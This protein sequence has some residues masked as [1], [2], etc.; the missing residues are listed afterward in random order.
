MRSR[1]QSVRVPRPPGRRGSG[2][3]LAPPPG[4]LGPPRPAWPPLPL[5]S[6]PRPVGRPDLARPIARGAGAWSVVRFYAHQLLVGLLDPC[7]GRAR[8]LNNNVAHQGLCQ[9]RIVRVHYPH[10]HLQSLI[11]SSGVHLHR[12]LEGEAAAGDGCILI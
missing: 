3:A 11:Q 7:G 1:V 4:L 9:H 12:S 2:L 10:R 6:R 8:L 5:S